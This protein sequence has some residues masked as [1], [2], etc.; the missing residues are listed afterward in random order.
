MTARS[1]LVPLGVALLLAAGCSSESR[2]SISSDV[3]DAVTA[4]SSAIGEVGEDAAE[5]AARNIAT[6]QG[7]EQFAN[8]GIELDGPLTCEATAVD[9]VSGLE[10]TCSGRTDSGES[11]EL[12]GMTDEVPGASVVELRGQFVGTVD[13]SPVFETTTLGG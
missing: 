4:V 12:T 2:D 1:L 10:V 6:Q 11:V 13:G 7:E 8:A 3:D 9:G 5:V